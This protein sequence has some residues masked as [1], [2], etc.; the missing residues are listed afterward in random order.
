MAAIHLVLGR[1]PDS[2]AAVERRRWR[3]LVRRRLA[4]LGLSVWEALE[5]HGRL[6]AARELGRLADQWQDSRPEL[7]QQLRESKRYLAGG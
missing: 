2:H 3:A 6:R 7:A 4:R 5:A 1:I